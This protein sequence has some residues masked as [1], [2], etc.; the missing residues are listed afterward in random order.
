MNWLNIIDISGKRYTLN[1]NQIIY[2]DMDY[3]ITCFSDKGVKIVLNGIKVNKEEGL[4]ST[5][6]EYIICRAEE[7]YNIREFFGYSE[8]N[9]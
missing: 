6:S 9:E 7:A 8:N 5:S 2:V 1:L 4:L 3:Y